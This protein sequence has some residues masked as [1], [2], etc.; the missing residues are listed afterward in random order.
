MSTTPLDLSMLQP[1]DYNSSDISV[2]DYSSLSNLGLDAPTID[3]PLGTDPFTGAS[4]YSGDPGAPSLTQIGDPA[5]AGTNAYN[6]GLLPLSNPNPVSDKTI[7]A[8]QY[9]GDAMSTDA[10][11]PLT[12]AN[13]S[14]KTQIGSNATVA[15]SP[16]PLPLGASL[17]ASLFGTGASAALGAAKAGTAGSPTSASKTGGLTGVKSAPLTAISNP[18][19]GTATALII[20]IVASIIGIILWSFSGAK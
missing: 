5:G 20:G 13:G 14:I 2:Q 12:P 10:N 19:G 7:A 6:D 1:S 15:G 8:S 17:W 9:S 11:L 16:A 18:I 3:T 4:L